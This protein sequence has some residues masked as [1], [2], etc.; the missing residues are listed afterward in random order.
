MKHKIL[1]D[2]QEIEIIEGGKTRPRRKKVKTMIYTDG[3]VINCSKK[4][5]IHDEFIINGKL[6]EVNGSTFK[7]TKLAFEDAN[8]VIKV[9][10]VNEWTTD[11]NI[12]GLFDVIKD[13][14]IYLK[15]PKD[16]KTLKIV[17]K[18][19]TEINRNPTECYYLTP[20]FESRINYQNNNPSL[21]NEEDEGIYRLKTRA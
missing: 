8:Y 6:Y 5:V 14:D 4:D 9:I 15:N 10:T 16:K 11:G 2:N 17:K 21:Y 20:M 13:I 7:K 3:N 18:T 12:H 19:V 1:D